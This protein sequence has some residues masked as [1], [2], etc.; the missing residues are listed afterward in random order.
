MSEKYA[1]QTGNFF[2][3]GK[4][5]LAVP[6]NPFSDGAQKVRD[7]KDVKELESRYRD[8][9]EAKQK[10]IE[11]RLEGLEIIP[12]GNRVIVMPYG[13]NPYVK[14]LTKSGIYVQPTGTFFN[15]DS[16]TMDTMEEAIICGAIIEIGPECKNVRIGDDIYF[17]KNTAAPLP[18]M[19]L[20]Y[21]TLPE[22]NIMAIINNDLK[23]RLKM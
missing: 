2:M 17:N 18:F 14:V 1:K 6:E 3:P 8:A 7:E 22:Q 13:S 16:G 11:E 9:H 23:T 15:P 19:G 21:Q 12:N 20:G 4:S 5:K 10:E